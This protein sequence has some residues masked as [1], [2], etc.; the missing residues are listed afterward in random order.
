MKPDRRKEWKY[1]GCTITPVHSLGHPWRFGGKVYSRYWR[2][3]YPHGGWVHA[4][5]K[6][7][8]RR[9]ITMV[10]IG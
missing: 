6:D 4:S 1:K 10:Q 5:T 8:A 3:V 9:H 7:A 2:I